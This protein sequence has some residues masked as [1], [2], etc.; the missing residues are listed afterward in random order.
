MLVNCFKKMFWF[1]LLGEHNFNSSSF[2]HLATSHTIP[3]V[4]CGKVFSAFLGN[5]VFRC[6][7][8]WSTVANVGCVKQSKSRILNALLFY[9]WTACVEKWFI[10]CLHIAIAKEVPQSRPSGR[11]KR[12]HRNQ[13]SQIKALTDFGKIGIYGIL[14]FYVSKAQPKMDAMEK[15]YGEE[16]YWGLWNT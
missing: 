13:D 12:L 6:D 16:L 1:V 7:P 3:L 9:V 14:L 5:A 11:R 8:L 10:N 2:H 15:C 4:V